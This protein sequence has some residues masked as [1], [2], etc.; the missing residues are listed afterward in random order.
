MGLNQIPP[1]ENYQKYKTESVS[2]DEPVRAAD[3]AAAVHPVVATT[4]VN[5]LH[6]L[7][8]VNRRD[9]DAAVLRRAGQLQ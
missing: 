5:K 4:F 8:A 6:L 2:C 1:S 7:S 3:H 9:W